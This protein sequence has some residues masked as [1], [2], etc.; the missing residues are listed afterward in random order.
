MSAW[1]RSHQFEYFFAVIT[2]IVLASL[3]TFYVRKP[4][5]TCSDQIQNQD[6][7]GV[8]CG[9]ACFKVCKNQAGSIIIKWTKVFPVREGFVDVAA[10]VSNPNPRYELKYV[11]Y[12]FRVYD[13]DQRLIAERKGVTFIQAAEQFVIF[14]PLI[15][16]NKRE[17]DKAFV[18]LEEPYSDDWRIQGN[19]RIPVFE[20]RNK[21]IAKSPL[22]VL[23]A[24]IKNAST[25]DAKDVQVIAVLNNSSGNVIGVSA[26]QIPLVTK[27]S[28]KQITLTWPNQFVDD[29]T[30]SE[31]YFHIPPISVK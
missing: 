11:P 17:A 31:I 24:I 26:A 21:E 8:D 6:E 15:D 3:G 16:T 13:N 20:V 27:V 25:F 18:T 29:I 30:S 10:L 9:G 14:E 19:V 12:S 28:E 22:P 4:A 1:G 5:P 23:N 7:E 2:V